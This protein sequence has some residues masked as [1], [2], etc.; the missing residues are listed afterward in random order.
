LLNTTSVRVPG[1]AAQADLAHQA[2]LVVEEIL[3]RDLPVHPAGDGAEVELEGL[4]VAAIS[5]PSGPFIG[6]VILPVH[7][8]IEQVQ[9][10]SAISTL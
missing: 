2:D 5:R 1:S 9:S 7:L 4:P 6:P 8:A 3:F 10:P